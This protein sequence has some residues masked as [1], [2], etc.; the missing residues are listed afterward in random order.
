[1]NLNGDLSVDLIN[2]FIPTI[3]DSFTVLTA[4]TRSGTFSNFIYPSNTVTM[5]LSNTVNSVIVRVTDVLTIPR[6]L[7]LSPEI[8]GLDIKLT[9]TSISNVTY[10][11]E[12]NPDLN[13]SNW[14][15]LPGDVTA[16]SNTASKTD[17]WMP[18]N[19]MYRVR[20]IP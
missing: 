8:A 2:G 3:N 14:N 18:T 4:G 7:L 5:Q 12:F 13:P 16:L 11:L 17:P 10:R 6:P 15:A 19:R 1:V 9:W 20:V